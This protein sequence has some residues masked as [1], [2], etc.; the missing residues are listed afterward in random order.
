MTTPAPWLLLAPD[1]SALDSIRQSPLPFLLWPVCEKPLLA[2]WLDEAV[3]Q[4]VPSVRIVAVDRPQLLR[5]YLDERDM[6]SRTIE[7]V[8]QEEAKG[9]SVCHRVDRLPGMAETPPPATPGDLLELWYQLHV[10]GLRRRSTGMVHLDHE[11]EPGIWFAPGVRVAPDV[12]FTAPCWVGS[13]ARIGGGCKIGPHAFVGPGSFVD[14]DVEMS[15]AIVCADTYL[16]AHT[17]LHRMAVQGGLLIDFN[18]G[19]GI[20]VLDDFVASS[21]RSSEGTPPWSEQIFA[22]L[23]GPVL[24]LLARL[25]AGR[26][27]PLQQTVRIGRSRELTLTTHINGPLG[28]RRAEWL[29]EVAAGHL[30]LVGVLPRSAAEWDALPADARSVLAEAPT[31]CFALSDLYHCHSPALADEWMHAVFQSASPDGTGQRLARQSLWKIFFTR[32]LESAPETPEL[33][34]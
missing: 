8:S 34:S 14:A 31:G 33:M 29:R 5:R 2:W 20:E 21:L 32:P 28:L 17:S 18:R 7:V 15:E 22:A 16:G 27:P 23:L 25:R 19:V 11:H 4:G 6:W 10:E 1:F 13:M 24:T 3:R 12:K 26:T 30:R 9:D